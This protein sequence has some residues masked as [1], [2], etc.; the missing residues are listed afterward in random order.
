MTADLPNELIELLEK[1]VLDEN[2]IFRDHRLVTEC[3]ECTLKACDSSQLVKAV[4]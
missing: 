4:I 1:I 3:A 2:S